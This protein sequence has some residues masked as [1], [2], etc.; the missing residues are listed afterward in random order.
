MRVPGN[1]TELE[2]VR[3]HPW[4]T[5]E[6]PIDSRGTLREPLA[7]W[8]ALGRH[9]GRWFHLVVQYPASLEEWFVPAPTASWTP[10]AGPTATPLWPVVKEKGPPPP[11]G[12][13]H[14]PPRLGARVRDASPKGR[15]PQ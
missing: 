4:P 10:G 7:G 15:D 14:H 3:R 1:R 12:E 2:P 5:V 8:V 6:Y 11:G 9:A 13:P